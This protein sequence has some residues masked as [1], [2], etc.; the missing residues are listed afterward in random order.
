MVKLPGEDKFRKKAKK[1]IY[2]LEDFD[3][4]FVNNV[5]VKLPIP[6]YDGIIEDGGEGTK[7]AKPM[8]VV[9][10][11]MNAGNDE[12]ARQGGFRLTVG[13]LLTPSIGPFLLQIRLRDPM[14]LQFGV[15]GQPGS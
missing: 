11:N 8:P 9:M 2:R 7:V 15:E 1:P 13:H 14:V 5:R 10:P 3:Y 6:D 12:Y 4:D